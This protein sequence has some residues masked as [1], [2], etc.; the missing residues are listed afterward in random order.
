M[1][2]KIKQQIKEFAILRAKHTQ[3]WDWIEI[4][5][6]G[7]PIFKKIPETIEYFLKKFT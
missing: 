6:F 2:T 3:S 7:I 5:F 4:Y 1:R